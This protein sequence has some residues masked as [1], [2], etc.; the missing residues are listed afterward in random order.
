M[1]ENDNYYLFE[2]IPHEKTEFAESFAEICMKSDFNL[3]Q[4]GLSGSRKEKSVVLPNNGIT[5]TWIVV[6]NELD[7]GKYY[8]KRIISSTNTE[9][10][11]R[12]K[13]RLS[14]IFC[15]DLFNF[16]SDETE[17]QIYLHPYGAI[18][19][20]EFYKQIGEVIYD[21]DHIGLSD[22]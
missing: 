18:V 11:S 15:T 7:P 3:C 22:F 13:S 16:T 2:P 17:K 5:L 4:N 9:T 14:T 19:Y 6:Q 20:R 10:L 12:I 8:I 21:V 1:Q